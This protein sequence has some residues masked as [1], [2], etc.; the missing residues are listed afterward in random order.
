MYSPS[1][2]YAKH[3]LEY[4]Q[5]NLVNLDLRYLGLGVG[6]IWTIG[7]SGPVGVREWAKGIFGLSRAL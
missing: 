4:A 3:T 7:V 2:S 6:C 1:N 5:C